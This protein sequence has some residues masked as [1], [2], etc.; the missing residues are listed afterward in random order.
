MANTE[1]P[2]DSKPPSHAS[3]PL[4][5]P[6]S[7]PPRKRSSAAKVFGVLILIVV[8]V[9]A[10][11]WLQHQRAS[12]KAAGAGGAAGRNSTGRGG[13]SGPVP[14]IGGTVT[15]R[16]VPIFLDGLGTVQ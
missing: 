14:V 10:G 2:G 5:N 1:N 15:T 8:A 16:N 9:T 12:K 3:L 11:I 7:G 4:A 13:F 6:E